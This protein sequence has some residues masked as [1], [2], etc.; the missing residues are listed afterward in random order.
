MIYSM[1]EI[2][3]PTGRLSVRNQPLPPVVKVTPGQGVHF[4]GGRFGR[5]MF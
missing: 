4:F 3:R 5:Q 2:P 1:A